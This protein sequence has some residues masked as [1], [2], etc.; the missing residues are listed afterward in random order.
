MRALAVLAAA[1]LAALPA[2]LTAQGLTFRMGR[3]FDDGGWTAYNIAWNHPLF[4]P[5]DAQLG[6]TLLRGP[7]ASERLF[8]ATFDASIFRGGRAGLYMIGGMG[9]GIG[10]GVAESWWSSWSAG[11]GY[12]LMPAHFFSLGIETRYREMRPRSRSG[13]ELA[14]RLSTNFGGAGPRNPDAPR[15]PMPLGPRE[16]EMR[17]ATATSEASPKADPTPAGIRLATAGVA[18]PASKAAHER[19]SEVIAIAEGEIGRRY[20][21]GGTGDPGDGFDC[22]G[23][24]QYAYER[25]GVSL[26][27][28]SVDQARAGREVGRDESALLPGDVLTFAGNGRAVTHVGLYIGDGRF[29]HSASRGVQI[30]RLGEDDPNGRYWYRRWV[31]ARRVIAAH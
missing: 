26:P 2:S 16:S 29:I 14:L 21:L 13:A 5:L 3:L 27:R 23:L 7:A 24:I 25:I 31:G 9:A 6:G 19:A 11:L 12:E 18:K 28:R 8:G 30:S 10:T 20:R 1:S 4:G 17:T 15:G 22:S